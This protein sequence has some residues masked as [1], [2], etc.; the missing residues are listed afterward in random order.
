MQQ[1][2]S[3]VMFWTSYSMLGRF[4]LV[5][6][7]Y[8][9]YV[10][11]LFLIYKIC[12]I[13]SDENFEVSYGISV[14]TG[15]FLLFHI[16]TRPQ[17]FSFILMTAELLVL[18]SYAKNGRT[19]NLFVLPMISLLMVNL[20]ASMWPMIFVL[21]LPYLLDAVPFR[22]KMLSGA[23]YKAF[24]LCLSAASMTAFGFIN[25]YGANAMTYLLRS[26]GVDAI[27]VLVD[28]MK[29]PDI[30]SPFGKFIFGYILAVAL[31][32]ICFRKGKTTLRYILLTLGPLYLTLSATRGFPIFVICSGFPLACYL[33]DAKFKDSS[34]TKA[35]AKTIKIRIVL[36]SLLI[37]L[38]AAG[39]VRN[40]GYLAEDIDKPVAKD[41]VDYLI[42]RYDA[43]SIRLYTNYNDG[44]YAEFMGVKS[45][46][47]TRAEVF[48]KACNG[49][50]DILN[51]YVQLQCGLYDY[52]SFIE[53]YGFTHILASYYDSLFVSLEND[54]DYI[55]IYEDD[56]CRVYE[57]VNLP[58]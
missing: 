18:E 54:P 1:W 51:D 11:I 8:I 32:Y 42:S 6:M 46:L 50:D 31:T 16:V 49:K 17:I 3:S 47:D 13:A 41:P 19:R 20:H 53:K 29:V 25:P 27:N 28:E 15:S 38:I 21:M 52:R 10:V 9:S 44:C 39:C 22:T 34:A 23:G 2:L 4:G 37:A 30:K 33:K 14:L 24:P 7:V 26:Y 56:Y 36:A 57:P 48:I 35:D 43:D 12:M 40:I 5:L 55:V 58:N 45:F